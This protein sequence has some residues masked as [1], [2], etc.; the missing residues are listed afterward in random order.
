MVELPARALSSLDPHGASVSYG[1]ILCLALG[2]MPATGCDLLVPFTSSSEQTDAR[3]AADLRGS[4]DGSESADTGARPDGQRANADGPPGDGAAPRRDGAP[5]PAEASAAI[6]GAGGPDVSPSADT[7]GVDASLGGGCSTAATISQQLGAKMVLC[8]ASGL[9]SYS[10]CDA[11]RSCA[12]GWH[13]C[14]ASEYR[15]AFG[16]GSPFTAGAPA[17]LAGCVREG[18]AKPTSPLDRACTSCTKTTNVPQ[19]VVQW[20][21][22]GSA[23]PASSAPYI[24][25]TT[26]LTC[27]RAGENIANNAAYWRT[28]RSD[29]TSSYAVCCR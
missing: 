6:D 21:C 10:Q 27:N 5:G 14:T 13:L 12:P 18:Q 2:L 26:Y 15:A 7:G 17:W 16:A 8:R 25:L 11:S 3:R 22:A 1:A 9:R 4:G 20:D 19:A 29:Q 28:A 24:G 23:A